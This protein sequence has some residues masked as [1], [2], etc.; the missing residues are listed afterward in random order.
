MMESIEIKTLEWKQNDSDLTIFGVVS[1][2]RSD[3]VIGT[4]VNVTSKSVK[5]SVGAKR[6]KKRHYHCK[7]ELIGKVVPGFA[8]L[9]V[10]DGKIEIGLKKSEKESWKRLTTST[11]FNI[12]AIPSKA[13]P[14]KP[15]PKKEAQEAKDTK[16]IECKSESSSSKTVSNESETNAEKSESKVKVESK[17]VPRPVKPQGPK[18][19]DKIVAEIEKDEEKEEKNADDVF[20]MLYGQADDDAK[21]AMMKSFYESKGSVLSMDWKEVGKKEVKPYA[22]EKKDSDVDSD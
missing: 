15:E 6:D 10:L 19:W 4:T 13:V 7:M 1:D 14:S 22:D 2:L 3:D 5:F 8:S 12:K 21:R 9:K 20:K 18:N 11:E 17:P 16:T